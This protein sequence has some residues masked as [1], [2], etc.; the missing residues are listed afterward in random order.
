MSELGWGCAETIHPKA[1]VLHLGNRSPAQGPAR[2]RVWSSD[3][4]LSTQASSRA[5]ASLPARTQVWERGVIWKWVPSHA[6]TVVTELAFWTQT[7]STR[8]GNILRE[9]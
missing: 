3:A 9:V 6:F 5:T 8:Q 2:A 1:F 4:Q 7:V